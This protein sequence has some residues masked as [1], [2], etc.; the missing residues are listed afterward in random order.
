MAG[1]SKRTGLT[2]STRQHG[3]R[4]ILMLDAIESLGV[5]KILEKANLKMEFKAG[6]SGL[7][8]RVC[9]VK[10]EITLDALPIDVSAFMV[11]AMRKHR[12]AIVKL[13]SEGC[14]TNSVQILH[15]LSDK[16]LD[17][18]QL[19]KQVKNY[20]TTLFKQSME[21]ELS[22]IRDKMIGKSSE[23]F[24]NIKKASDVGFFVKLMNKLS[25]SGRNNNNSL[26][27]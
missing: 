18:E 27:K 3:D 19:Q 26:D 8:D 9:K 13:R 21:T 24:S 5:D 22:H 23:P 17:D 7:G 14:K 20:I 2:S 16:Y 1:I 11:D 10:S 4:L 6:L 12:L 25:T 15:N